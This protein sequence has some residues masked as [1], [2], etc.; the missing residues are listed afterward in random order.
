[1]DEPIDFS[2]EHAR[3]VLRDHITMIAKRSVEKHGPA[4]TME[5]LEQ[6]IADRDV[7]RRETSWR[8]D[9]NLLEVGEFAMAIAQ[10]DGYVIAVHDSFR[11][12][13]E[14]LPI[15]IAYHLATVNYGE[16]VTEV[17]EAELFGASLLGMD[18]D[19]FYEK[20]CAFAD[21]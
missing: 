21:R 7:I 2:E 10:G 12:D 11:D 5:V 9:N 8:F 18:V 19:V 16:H 15:L 14:A 1:M 13:I 4:T 3:Q 20:M 6:V 17:G